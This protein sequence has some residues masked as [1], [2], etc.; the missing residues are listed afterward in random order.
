[1]TKPEGSGGEVTTRTCTEQLLYEVHDPSAYMTPDAVAD[2]SGVELDEVGEDRV[3]VRG[4]AARPRTDSLKVNVCYED[5]VVGEGRI[6]Y[7]GPG[8]LERADLAGSVVRERLDRREIE[9]SE[10][11]VDH[12]GVDSLHGPLGRERSGD[13]Y[14]VRLRVAGRCE[15][16]A[17][18]A[19]IGREVETLYTNGPAGGGG[20]ERW[21]EPV[22]GIV[23][24]L[25]DRAPIDHEIEFHNTGRVRDVEATT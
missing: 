9:C 13:P 21:T 20:V 5:S 16:D 3:R 7:G 17:A 19:A 10:L 14:E 22:V 18:A 6:S 1:M 2:F 12:V 23:S 4:A 11:R 25:V 15:T 24:L 8:A